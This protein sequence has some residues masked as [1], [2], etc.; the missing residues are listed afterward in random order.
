MPLYEVTSPEGSVYQIEGPEGADPSQIIAQISGP[1]RAAP[2]P[3]APRTMADRVLEAPIGAVEVGLQDATAITGAVPAALGYAGAAIGKALGADVDPSAVQAGIQRALTYQPMSESGQELSAARSEFWSPVIEPVANAY[4][5]ATQAVGERAPLAGE[6]MREAP[7]AFQ[8]AS[9]LV[10]AVSAVK[11]ATIAARDI[12]RETLARP[13][14]PPLTAEEVVSRIDTRQSM[15]SASAA[16][17]LQAVSPELREA[18]VQNAQKT[19]GAVNPEVLGRHIEADTLPV[20]IRL[21]EGQATQDPTL[22]SYEMK[23][24]ESNK[25]FAERFNE[26]SRQLAENVRAIR[27][28]AAPDVFSTNATEH[29][30]TLISAYKARDEAAQQAINQAYEAA[31][32]ANGGDLPMNGRGFVTAADAALKKSMKGRYVPSEVAADLADIRQ[33]GAMNF[34]TF[35]N[36]RTNLAA[37]ARKA[38]RAGDG[39]TAAA[40]RIVRDA[41]EGIEPMGRAKQVKP[42]FDKAR[43]LAK[44]RFDALDADPAYRAAVNE[45]VTPDRFVNRFVINGARDD[46]ALMRRNLADDEVAAQTIGVSTLDYLR[47]AARLNPHY[48][49]NFAAVSYNKA[50]T[51]LSPKMQSL[52]SPKVAEQLDQLGKVAGYTTAQPRGSFVNNANSTVAGYAMNLAKGAAERSGN[53]LVPGAELGTLARSKLEASKARKEARRSTAPGAGLDRLPE[54][55]Q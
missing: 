33:S 37:E 18:I 19:G 32:D 41:L 10:P 44:A 12:A 2:P 39:N 15:G 21:T 27:D 51:K 47:E 45:T 26:Q 23:L 55:R 49:G 16:P 8:A 38:E 30:D 4:G 17:S 34:E 25:E 31:R 35:E 54:R 3:Q 36:L 48:E 46:L 29:G 13:K 14:A 50:L 40:V 43:S 52:V 22:I 20:R 9:A 53:A 28:E 5:R 1:A 7:G 11:P 24:S 6:M 42:L